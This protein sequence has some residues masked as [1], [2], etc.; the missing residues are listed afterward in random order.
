MGKRAFTLI[1]VLVVI[2]VIA[3]LAAI[4][5]PVFA[6]AKT[7]A[8][9]TACTSNLMQVGKATAMYL[10][11]FDGLMPWVPD[12]YLQLTPAVDAAGKKYVSMGAFMAILDPYAKKRRYLAHPGHGDR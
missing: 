7:D 9:K 12:E 11:D 4:Q 2:A 6:K 5:F 10:N 8:K 1:E 3:I